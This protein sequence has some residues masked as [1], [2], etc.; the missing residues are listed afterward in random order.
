M[1]KVV[2]KEFSYKITGLLFKAHNDLGRY[3]NEKQYAD[4]FETLLNKN[5]IK[6]K[7]ECHLNQSFEG[8]KEGRCICD[9]VVDDKIVIEFKTVK[10][11]SREDYFQIKRYLSCSNLRLG[12]LVNFR[13]NYITPK[14]I[15]NNELLKKDLQINL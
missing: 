5:K 12:I 3:K 11:L 15:L 7:R 13:Q 2:Y 14:R 10:F 4:Y 9:F 1:D 8:E 6:Y